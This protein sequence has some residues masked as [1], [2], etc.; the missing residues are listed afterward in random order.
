MVDPI[1]LNRE[2]AIG[3]T[4]GKNIRESLHIV[5]E[6]TRDGESQARGNL[7]CAPFRK[8]ELIL[9]DH[10]FTGIPGA[11]VKEGG[12]T[13]RINRSVITGSVVGSAVRLVCLYAEAGVV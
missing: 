9:T 6:V 5:E 8:R 1:R 13:R 12:P 11:A 7:G 3:G 10:L 2:N 4:Q